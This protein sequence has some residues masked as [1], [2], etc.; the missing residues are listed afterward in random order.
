M[1][2]LT[3]IAMNIEKHYGSFEGSGFICKCSPKSNWRTV[4]GSEMLDLM[5]EELA[6][7]KANFNICHKSMKNSQ[8]MISKRVSK[9]KHCVQHSRL[10]PCRFTLTVADTM[11]L[12]R[13]RRR[14][15][16]PCCKFLKALELWQWRARPHRERPGECGAFLATKA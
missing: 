5:R 12:Q 7:M 13:L 3:T 4:E 11:Q 1:R 10:F 2:G 8:L 9:K 14:L 6:V 16:D 15:R